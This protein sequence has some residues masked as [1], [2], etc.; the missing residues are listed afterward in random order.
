MEKPQR[1]PRHHPF[2]YIGG[3]FLNAVVFLAV[4]PLIGG[5]ILATVASLS[6]FSIAILF[7]YVVLFFIT[8]PTSYF[9]ASPTAVVTGT[10]V[11]IASIWITSNR[12][13]YTIAA[14]AGGVVSMLLLTRSEH[15]MRDQE[16]VS[17]VISF[18]ISGAIA[19]LVCTRL[20]KPFRLSV[21]L[22]PNLPDQLMAKSK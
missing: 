11:A 6:K 15:L 19:A 22:G 3:I 12:S 21:Q 20:A 10:I 5:I 4:G 2:F 13:L 1:P 17:S 8:V 7:G 18:A 9:I 14:G 16:P